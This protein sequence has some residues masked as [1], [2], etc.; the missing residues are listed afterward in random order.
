MNE[1]N[2]QDYFDGEDYIVASCCTVLFDNFIG[3][4]AVCRAGLL[5]L[6]SYTPEDGH[7][8]RNM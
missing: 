8:G 4:V 1:Q 6:S 7:I 5:L 3:Y 2:I